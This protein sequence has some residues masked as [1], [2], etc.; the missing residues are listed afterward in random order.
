MEYRLPFP[1]MVPPR[2]VEIESRQRPLYLFLLYQ[3]KTFIHKVLSMCPETSLEHW[4]HPGME[5]ERN[6]LSS[7]HL[8]IVLAPNRTFTV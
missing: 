4:P 6:P 7:D 2:K 1:R 5:K 3:R 8:E